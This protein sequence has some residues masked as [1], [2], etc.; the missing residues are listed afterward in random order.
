MNKF[1]MFVLVLSLAA[2]AGLLAAGVAEYSQAQDD[3][4]PGKGPGFGGG[5]GRGARMFQESDTNHD[6]KLSWDEFNAMREK[7]AQ[8]M[9]KQTDKDHDG[10][11]S[12]EELR[13]GRQERMEK[14]KNFR[15][16]GGRP[17]NH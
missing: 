14:M 11:L 2:G 12:Q 15:H 3:V 4:E 6:Q 13:E 10:F 9:F 16:E 17:F 1:A 7:K 5:P 8:E